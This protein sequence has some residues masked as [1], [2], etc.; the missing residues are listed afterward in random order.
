MFCIHRPHDRNDGSHQRLG[1]HRHTFLGLQ[2]LRREDFLPWSPG[3][4]PSKGS[5]CSRGSKTDGGARADPAIKPSQQQTLPHQSMYPWKHSPSHHQPTWW[6]GHCRLSCS[7]ADLHPWPYSSSTLWRVNVHSRQEIGLM[8]HLCSLCRCMGS[9]NTSLI[10]WRPSLMIW[11]NN[12]WP[13]TQSL[14][15]E[16]RL[17]Y[18]FFEQIWPNKQIASRNY[19]SQLLG[20]VTIL[21]RHLF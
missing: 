14:C 1:W 10:S 7:A 15:W 5:G 19:L 6:V 3:L 16:G 2:D 11:W 18:T 12:M 13:R 17:S 21:R 4:S 20:G 9:W 8:W